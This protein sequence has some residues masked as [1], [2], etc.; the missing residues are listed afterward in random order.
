M[1]IQ[2]L[3]VAPYLKVQ[4]GPGLTARITHMCDHLAGGNLLAD[5]MYKA[6]DP[7]VQLR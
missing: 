6:V 1:R 5:L 7:R 3:A 2:R 4:R